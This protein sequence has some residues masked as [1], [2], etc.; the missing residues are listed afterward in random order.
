[1]PT[2]EVNEVSA[3]LDPVLAK[4]LLPAVVIDQADLA[5][6]LSEALLAAGMNVIE[7]TFRTA[8]AEE[9]I[10]NI[11]RRFPAMVLG[12]GTL[13]TADQ[14]SRARDAGATFGVAPGLSETVVR[15]AQKVGLQIVP[16]VVTPSEISRALELG[17]QVL[18]FFPADASGG[19]KTLKALGGAFG[20]TGVRFVPTGGIDSKNLREYLGLPIV[21]AVGGSWMVEKS[22]IAA[23]NWKQIELLTREALAAAGA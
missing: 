15:Q 13:L 16:G 19:V 6:P 3:R 17:C 23:R 14:V 8:A 9:A 5:I 7:V 4:R 12:A 1:M 18:K 11:G 10:R 22:L 21:A 20:H 2:T